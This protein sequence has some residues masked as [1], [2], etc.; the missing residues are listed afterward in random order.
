MKVK[1]PRFACYFEPTCIHNES[2]HQGKRHKENSNQLNDRFDSSYHT[3]EQYAEG[4]SKKGVPQNHL[5]ED[6]EHLPSLVHVQVVV[7]L[8]NLTYDVDL[9]EDR[10]KQKHPIDYR[11]GPKVGAVPVLA[12]RYFF[13]NNLRLFFHREGRIKQDAAVEVNGD[14]EERSNSVLNVLVLWMQRVHL[15]VLSSHSGI[16]AERDQHD[17]DHLDVEDDEQLLMLD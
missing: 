8:V 5:S 7:I 13:V 1:K 4:I 15:I 2:G 16:N 10:R 12:S 6:Q 17:D 9:N 14:E 3:A 11:F